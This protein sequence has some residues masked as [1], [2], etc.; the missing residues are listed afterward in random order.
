MYIVIYGTTLPALVAA[1]LLA[2]AGNQVRLPITVT[3]LLSRKVTLKEPGLKDL[4]T[5]QFE[6]GRLQPYDPS[7]PPIK[8]DLHWLCLEADELQ[9][10]EQIVDHV[11]NHSGGPLLFLNQ[12]LFGIGSTAKLNERLTNQE[13]RCMVFVPDNLR[14]GQALSSFSNP[15]QVI[16]GSDSSWAINRI[17]AMIRVLLG[18]TNCTR[19]M[20]TKEAEFSTL[21]ANGM[22]AMRIS[23]I[24]ELAN[25]ADS[26]GVD[27]E[28]VRDA[29]AG[30]SRIGQHFL[31]PGCGFGG[32]KFSENLLLFSDFLKERR[33]SSLLRTVIDINE[34]QKETLFRRLWRAYD[35]NLKGKK[36]AIWGA[37]Y[38]PGSANIE[39]APSICTI[40][41]CLAQGVEV[42]VH[43]PLALD[44]VAAHYHNSD[45][46]ICCNTPE[47]AAAG[48]DAI[49]LV[50]EWPEYGMRDFPA[51]LSE[52]RRP[53]LLDGRN[54][55]DPGQM[56]EYG[57]QYQGIG[58]G[59]VQEADSL[60]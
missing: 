45:K 59:Q 23:Y 57:F 48:S 26:M 50:T 7:R 30:D 8:A 55:F 58:R 32:Q 18:H 15:D 10:A 60:S 33:R 24:N 2:Q 5:K 19:I 46:L 9:K 29:M 4:L 53:L 34:H 44:N 1:G 31:S 47:E 20:S 3:E 6:T 43:D 27:I 56:S 25:L 11:A 49:L 22:L 42:R 12:S 54:M 41:A 14:E 28:V 21:A 16:L 38:K 52:M 17:S 39:N 35:G 13:Q 36:I 40:D 37:A 51:I